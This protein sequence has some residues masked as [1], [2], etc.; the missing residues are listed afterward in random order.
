VR[1]YRSRRTFGSISASYGRPVKCVLDMPGPG[2]AG[3]RP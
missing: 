3:W 1:K 2:S